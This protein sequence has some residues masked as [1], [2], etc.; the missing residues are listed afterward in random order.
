MELLLFIYIFTVIFPFCSLDSGCIL[1]NTQR[2]DSPNLLPHESQVKNPEKSVREPIKPQVD[3]SKHD[4]RRPSHADNN[5][6]LANHPQVADQALEKGKLPTVHRRDSQE[7]KDQG[8]VNYEEWRKGKPNPDM[9][10]RGTSDDSKSNLNNVLISGFPRSN[11]AFLV[12]G[13]PTVKRAKVSYLAQTIR[14]LV[15]GLDEDER[16][17]VIIVVFITDFDTDAIRSVADDLNKKFPSELDS[18]LV[19]VIQAERSFYPSL[20]KVPKLWGDSPQRV[21]W[22]SKQCLDYAFLFKYCQDLGQ[23]Y[24]QIE[25]DV[26]TSKD[27]LKRIKETIAMN[28]RRKWSILEFGARGFIGMMYRAED[29]GRLSRFVKMYHWV[30]PVDLL[31]RQFNDFHLYGNPQ[32][33]RYKPPL[34]RH[35]GAFSSLDGQ[36]RKLEDIKPGFRAYTDSDNPPARLTTSMLNTVHRTRIT[37]PY[38][39]RRHGIFWSRDVEKMDY[40]LIEFEQPARVRKVIIDSGSPNA[41]EDYFGGA[42]LEY[43]AGDEIGECR[44]FKTWKTFEDQPQLIVESEEDGVVCKCI[45]VVITDVRKDKHKKVRWLVIREIAVWTKHIANTGKPAR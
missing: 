21:H 36:V 42:T 33:A 7:N 43:S 45:K 39:T 9:I 4:A 29:L 20:S 27:Y 13:V 12:I 8:V 3:Q 6:K 2:Q 16:N 30:F 11:Q 24:M 10:K 34:V 25:D 18:G 23:Y 28:K 22:R 41:P 19:R 26:T 35:V 44:E 14:D 40:V 31:Y 17:E 38:D 32:W 5:G 1:T 37:S 15:S